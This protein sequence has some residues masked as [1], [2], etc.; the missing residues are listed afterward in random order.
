VV[1][2]KIAY[3]TATAAVALGDYLPAKG[4][5]NASSSTTIL[6]PQAAREIGC[7]YSIAAAD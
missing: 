2:V 3:T 4:V 7:S 5:Q 1:A 6:F